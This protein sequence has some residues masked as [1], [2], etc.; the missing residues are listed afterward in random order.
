M[1]KRN[2][3]FK[4]AT[5]LL[6][7]EGMT[8]DKAI[9]V[10]YEALI[11]T[12]SDHQRKKMGHPGGQPGTPPVT[13]VEDSCLGEL[14]DCTGESNNPFRR[15]DGTCN[16]VGGTSNGREVRRGGGGGGKILIITWTLAGVA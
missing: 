12:R 8:K 15:I 9:E 7:K 4:R 5:E 2:A 11:N 1:A 10:A 3:L 16:N 14:P 13:I 6:E